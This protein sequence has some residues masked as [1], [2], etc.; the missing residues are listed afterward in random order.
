M[1]Y[2][3]IINNNLRCLFIYLII[4]YLQLLNSD[5]QHRKTICIN[6]HEQ[7]T[8]RPACMAMQADLGVPV[9]PI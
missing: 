1:K 7:R 4:R 5:P 2:D 6:M 9:Q 8:P 3:I